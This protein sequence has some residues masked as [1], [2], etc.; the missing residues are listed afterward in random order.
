MLTKQ[1]RRLGQISIS[2]VLKGNEVVFLKGALRSV[3]MPGASDA[4]QVA[5]LPMSP[6]GFSL[7]EAVVR[8]AGKTLSK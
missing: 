2:F 7:S 5:D 8:R 4:A 6:C 1:M 3:P